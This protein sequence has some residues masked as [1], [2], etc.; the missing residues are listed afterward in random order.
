MNDNLHYLAASAHEIIKLNN[1]Y[2]LGI[3][4]NKFYYISLIDDLVKTDYVVKIKCP[5]TA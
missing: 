1:D 5:F 3:F 2:N 4:M